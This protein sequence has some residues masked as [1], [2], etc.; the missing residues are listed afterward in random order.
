[1]FFGSSG[2]GFLSIFGW[3]LVS[4]TAAGVAA[5]GGGLCSAGGLAALWTVGG[6]ASPTAGDLPGSDCACNEAT[7]SRLHE[8]VRSYL[9]IW[10]RNSNRPTGE[11]R[12]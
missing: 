12:N 4:A 10:A 11:I 6:F 3:P 5:T 8:V 1:M 7:Q 9:I 2:G